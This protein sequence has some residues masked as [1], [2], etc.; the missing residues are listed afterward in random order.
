MVGAQP[1]RVL[2]EKIKNEIAASSVN[3]RPE[4]EANA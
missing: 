1:R 4:A 2:E 3:G